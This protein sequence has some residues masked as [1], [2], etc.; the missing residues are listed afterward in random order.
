MHASVA[1]ALLAAACPLALAAPAESAPDAASPDTLRLVKTSEQD[2]GQW[3][4][5]KDFW[6]RFTSQ[7]VNFV[8]I[9]DI[10]VPPAPPYPVC[11]RM[12]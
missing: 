6:D 10:K 5:E 3:V 2:P 11:V 7:G 4:D 12:C 8:D 9:T 1:L